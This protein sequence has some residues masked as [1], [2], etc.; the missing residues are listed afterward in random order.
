[1]SA[2]ISSADSAASSANAA[3]SEARNLVN[4]GTPLLSDM[5]AALEDFND[6]R[7]E[8]GSAMQQSTVATTAAN[9][10][11]EAITYMT[12]DA[13]SVS[14]YSQTSADIS[15]V[16]GHK[17]IHFCIQKGETGESY[18][19]KGHAYDTLS[20][21]ES[22]IVD[23][24]VGDQ[25]NVGTQAPYNVYRWTG[26]EWENQGVIGPGFT[27]ISNEEITTIYNGGTIELPAKKYLNASALS[28]YISSKAKPALDSKVDKVTGKG[29]STNDFTTEY[30]NRIDS[31]AASIVSLGSNKVDKIS[32]K[33]LSTNDFTTAYKNKIDSNGS[34]I[35]QLST[36]K[37]DADFTTKDPIL[38]G[39]WY[40]GYF[41]V[42]Y[43]G[44]VYKLSGSQ[45]VSDLTGL[46]NYV[47]NSQIATSS[48]ARTY[49]GIS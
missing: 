29:L 49:L 48:E 2:K 23:P 45:F 44:V 47:Q 19:I 24:E 35:T 22:D 17:H 15:D 27:D 8:F 33:S 5:T 34:L 4:T 25:Y 7:V 21:L 37:M 38:S 6:M 36:S 18:I 3:A 42:S 1:M 32:G 43:D 31:Y 11:S 28:F 10:A 46:G 26:E 12:V 39:S 16:D 13:E 40:S 20:D 41:V 30:K 9:E 14:P